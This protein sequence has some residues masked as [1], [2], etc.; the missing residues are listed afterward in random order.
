MN[1][2]DFYSWLVFT[3]IFCGFSMLAAIAFL[4]G[5]DYGVGLGFL[6]ALLCGTAFGG[7]N[8]W[9]IQQQW[10][11]YQRRLERR[12]LPILRRLISPSDR[13]YWES[14]QRARDV[15]IQWALA[16]AED[17]VQAGHCRDC[18]ASHNLLKEYPW[19]PMLHRSGCS[20]QQVKAQF[21]EVRLAPMVELLQC[22]DEQ[23][24]LDRLQGSAR[25]YLV[26]CVRYAL[27]ECG[28]Q[29]DRSV[30]LLYVAQ[31]YQRFVWQQENQY[32]SFELGRKLIQ[33][34]DLEGLRQESNALSR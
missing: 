31:E 21:D 18:G 29:D 9:A 23:I 28:D 17:C 7:Y 6:I 22:E 12:Q 32:A 8:T 30:I 26:Q 33:E 3:I 2:R 4:M 34:V 14:I 16:R 15:V 19:D 13:E 25:D 10:D 5:A 1:R 24:F 27:A 11:C 20:A